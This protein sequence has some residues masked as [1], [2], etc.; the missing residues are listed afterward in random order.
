MHKMSR[1]LYF[2]VMMKTVILQIRIAEKF[3]K[4]DEAAISKF[5]RSPNISKINTELVRGDANDWSAIIF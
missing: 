1:F 4:L 2:N 3:Q 5:A